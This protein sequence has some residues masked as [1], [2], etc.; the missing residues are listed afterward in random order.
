MMDFILIAVILLIVAAAAGYVIKAKKSGAKCIGCPVE[1]G[2][3]S[4]HQS[5]TGS[6]A[7]AA[8]VRTVPASKTSK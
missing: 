8:A 6:C 2:C 5:H 7:M 3:C 1:G 4:H